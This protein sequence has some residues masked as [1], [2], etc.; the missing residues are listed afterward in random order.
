MVTGSVAKLEALRKLGRYPELAKLATELIASNPDNL[1]A[2]FCLAVARGELGDLPGGTAAAET[3][4]RLRPDRF[5]T[6]LIYSNLLR[7][8]RRDTE[9]VTAAR[10]AIRLAPE[11]HQPHLTLAT[12]LREQRSGLPDAADAAAHAVRLAPADA[13]CHLMVADIAHRRGDLN[14]AETALLAALRLQPNTAALHDNLALVRLKRGRVKYGVDAATGFAESL[15][16]SPDSPDARNKLV[17]TVYLLALNSWKAA[18]LCLLL[19]FVAAVTLFNTM[20]DGARGFGSPLQWSIAAATSVLVA[21]PAVYVG[22]R[23]LRRIPARLRRGVL[24]IGLSPTATR[25]RL[26]GSAT[27]V[28]VAITQPL[29]PQFPIAIG[30]AAALVVSIVVAL[31]LG[32]PRAVWRAVGRE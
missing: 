13:E 30:G 26:A 6:W 3:A 17:L 4:I 9:A 28:A 11:H 20:L 8:Q 10:E 24:R 25:V 23:L 1:S 12:V 32:H 21:A 16:I 31:V 5:Q 2:W 27:A 22:W 18:S 15:A 29:V 19:G 14:T 7:H